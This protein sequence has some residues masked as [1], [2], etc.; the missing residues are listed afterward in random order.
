[1]K[2]TLLSLGIFTIFSHFIWS[3]API[4]GLLIHY[5]FNNTLEDFSGNNR[6]ANSPL[7]P[8]NYETGENSDVNGAITID[9]SSDVSYDF[10][11]DLTAFNSISNFTIAVWVKKESSGNTYDNIFELGNGELF[12][13]FL[14]QGT[15]SFPEYGYY[16]QTLNYY[17]SN[18]GPAGQT[19]SFWNDWH[20]IVLTSEV[21]GNNRYFNLYVDGAAYYN[22]MISGTAQDAAILFNTSAVNGSKMFLGYRP[23]NTNL[24]MYGSMQDFYLYNR[25]LSLTEVEAV[26][27]GL[28]DSPATASAT[29]SVCDHLTLN[30]QGYYTSGTY[31]QNFYTASGCDSILTIH[32]TVDEFPNA[33]IQPNGNALATQPGMDSYQWIDCST[34]NPVSGANQS[35]YSPSASGN[36]AVVVNNGLCTDTSACFAYSTMGINETAEK[37][38]LIYPNPATTHVEIKGIQTNGTVR[39]VDA[40]GR[41]IAEG[42]LDAPIQTG[43]L[44]EGTYTVII[45]SDGKIVHNHL[46]IIK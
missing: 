6:D 18:G 42:S 4:N 28:C 43:Q 22:N 25:A 24:D 34:G 19:H 26:Y 41:Q 2:Q 36:Y 3:Q 38:F 13:R 44:S 15:N 46:Q 40:L 9:G 7:N 30:G 29:Y 35:V 12:L 11:N 20:H 1:M 45:E 10:W 37:E 32:V 5:P 17:G 21:I 8:V 16:S 31:T 27:N 33:V 23:G 39:I 14:N